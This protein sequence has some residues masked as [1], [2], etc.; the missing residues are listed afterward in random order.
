[1]KRVQPRSISVTTGQLYQK[2][3]VRYGTLYYG[4]WPE[5]PYAS[6]RFLISR[7]RSSAGFGG[8]TRGLI[9]QLPR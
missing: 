6:L 3:C 5:K 2:T 7:Q 1:M 4:S 9:T 8:M